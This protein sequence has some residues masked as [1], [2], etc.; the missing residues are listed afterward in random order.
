MWYTII[1]KLKSLKL[2][3]S[4]TKGEVVLVR[5]DA[6]VP[7][8][9]GVVVAGAD[10]RLQQLKPTIEWLRKQGARVVLI[11]HLGR[12]A[13]RWSLVNGKWRFE[14][15]DTPI[16]SLEPV[17]QR[18]SA[19]LG[20]EVPLL[21]DPVG[22]TDLINH[23]QSFAPGDVMCLENIRYYA[24]EETNEM[25][26]SRTLASLGSVFVNDAFGVCHRRAASVAGVTQFL[27]H[28]AGLLLAEEV[29]RLSEVREKPDR[30]FVI[31]LGGAKISSKIGLVW[32]ML[33]NANTVLVGGG[34]ATTM[35]GALGYGVGGSLAEP[36]L[37]HEVSR[38]LL[39]RR[40]AKLILP[41]DVMVRS[42]TTDAVR[43]MLVPLSAAPICNN[44]EEI[45]D[46][47]PAT[48]ELFATTI[49]AH[50]L[51]VWNG[52][53]GRAEDKRFRAGSQAVLEA[54]RLVPKTIIGGGET[55]MFAQAEQALGRFS[56]V[57]TGGGA[58]LEFLEGK[59]LPGIEALRK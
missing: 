3:E 4:W 46:S 10:F 23:I 51:A 58:M 44:D 52:T 22:T 28:Y 41:I 31:I 36:D 54:M 21:S 53:L 35:W 2:R 32:R 39:V 17:A 1:M 48:N 20:Y 11:A 34:I 16:L 6:N 49:M 57:S 15:L 37:Y 9:N 27:E 42:K 25:N 7:L 13:S 56:F 45:I 33:Q 38:A 43:T 5:V 55:V 47:G 18:L 30:P 29:R 14:Q 19:I 8:E 50:K 24:G 26:F 59:I 40:A 12:P